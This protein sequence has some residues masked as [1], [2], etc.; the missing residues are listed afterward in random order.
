MGTSLCFTFFSL[1][2]FVITF[3]QLLPKANSATYW[4]DTQAL[5]QFKNGLD[6]N[7]L[8][9]GSC[10]ASWDFNFNPCDS[11]FT[12]KFTCGFR[13]DAVISGPSRVTELALDSAGYSGSLASSSW[14]L[15]Y[16]QTLDLSN[17]YFS[18]SIPDSLSNLTRLSRLILSFNSLTGSVPES[19]GSLSGLQ[20]LYLDNNKLEG[21]MPW[22]VNGLKNLARLGVQG[23]KLSGEFPDLGQL[24][25]LNLLDASDNA[26]SG[27]LPAR[28]PA[29]LVEFIMRNNQLEG[30]IPASVTSM[31][32]LQPTTDSRGSKQQPAPRTV[33]GLHGFNA[34][35]LLPIPGEQQVHGYDSDPVRHPGGFTRCRGVAVLEAVAGWELPVRTH[36]GP[37]D[38]GDGSGFGYGPVGEEL[39]VPVSDE[40]FFLRGW[41]AE[42]AGGV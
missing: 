7:S 10:L 34:Q 22:S 2:L 40:F 4:G 36:T 26:I 8:S 17:N 21:T 14:N 31:V 42:V 33:T 24:G 19:I 35:A 9:P 37:V 32:N 29:S 39:L 11:L 18:G 30:N 25:S 27:E 3:T 41:R 16:L 12:E 28:L 13:C 5:K 6:P 38:E 15:P 20:E 23:N 1:T